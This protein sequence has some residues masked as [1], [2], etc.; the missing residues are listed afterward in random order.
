VTAPADQPAKP[1]RTWRPMAA[2]A[3]AILAVAGAVLLL[4]FSSRPKD[5]LEDKSAVVTVRPGFGCP[6]G[7]MEFRLSPAE[8]AELQAVMRE[9]HPHPASNRDLYALDGCGMIF[10]TFVSSGKRH[11]V[12]VWNGEYCVLGPDINCGRVSDRIQCPGI[13]WTLWAMQKN[14]VGGEAKGVGENTTQKTTGPDNTLAQVDPSPP[15]T[16]PERTHRLAPGQTLVAVAE[17][18]Y[19]CRHYSSVIALHNRIADPA[20]LP[21]DTVLRVP[22]LKSLLSDEGLCKVAGNEVDAILRARS[23]F[24]KHERRL[25]DL[26]RNLRDERVTVPAE[27]KADLLAAAA[28]L[29]E[30]VR[31]LGE[32]KPGVAAAPQKMIGQLRSAATTIRD[33]AGG[34]NDG[35]GYDIDMVQQ[36]LVQ[37][38]LN[39]IHWS[40]DGFR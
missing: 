21:A 32:R 15:T 33:L 34:A 26:R 24:M 22:D 19:G 35:Y 30:A 36:H 20:R 37:A 3:A 23:L 7:T 40:R 38:M 4:F 9:G 2:W 28:S 11:E 18:Y 31:A 14:R 6:W 27:M 16:E 1:R 29:D 17:R 25:F 10:L 5:F 13:C 39:G 8:V 12:H